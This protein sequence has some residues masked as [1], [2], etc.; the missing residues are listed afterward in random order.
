MD[1][2]VPLGSFLAI[3]FLG[4]WALVAFLIW[5]ASYILY[6]LVLNPRMVRTD[7]K[8]MAIGREPKWHRRKYYEQ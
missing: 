8:L 7:E 6:M 5:L 1:I 2:T 4:F 3:A